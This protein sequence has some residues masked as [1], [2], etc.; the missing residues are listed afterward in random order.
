MSAGGQTIFAGQELVEHARKE[1]DCGM[2]ARNIVLFIWSREWGDLF[3]A[4][5]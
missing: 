1:D 5:A 2:I 4:L 3:Q